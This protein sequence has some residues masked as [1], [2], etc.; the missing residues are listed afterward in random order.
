MGYSVTDQSTVQTIGKY[1]ILGTLGR[2]SMGVVYK[3]LDPE[4]ERVVA[5]KTLRKINPAGADTDTALE[6]F[7]LEARSAGKIR[8]PNVITI[9]EV[10]IEGDLPYLVMDYVQGQSLADI[11]KSQ[12]RI[13]PGFVIHLLKQAAAGIDAAHRCG[14]IHRDIKPRNMIVDSNKQLYVLDFG[15]A[16]LDMTLGEIKSDK[17]RSTVMGTPGY[18]SPEQVLDEGV[19]YRTDIFSLAVVAFECFTGKRP[20]PGEN[21]TEIVAN[22][23]NAKPLALTSLAPDLPLA[24]EADFERALSKNKDERFETAAEMIGCFEDSLR[25]AGKQILSKTGSPSARERKK[26]VWK[27]L[28]VVS[29][30]SVRQ[31]SSREEA[32]GSDGPGR[33]DYP[34]RSLISANPGVKK[35]ESSYYGGP[36]KGAT[37]GSIFQNSNYDLTDSSNIGYQSLSGM[38]VL[39]LLFGVLCIFLGTYLLWIIT[40]ENSQL[41]GPGGEKVKVVAAAP[42]NAAVL[43]FPSEIDLKISPVDYDLPPASK[44]VHEMS[45][46]ELLGVLVSNS[47]P[48][49]ELVSALKEARRRKIPKLVN[50]VVHVLDNQSY[51]VRIEAVKILGELK[52]RRAVPK[53]VELLDDID[54]L[55]RIKTAQS[56]G[57]LGS[58]KAIGYLTV[59]L[60]KEQLPGVKKAIKNAIEK[61]NGFP[62]SK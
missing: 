25:R 57:M 5:I 11:I 45:S 7:R 49:G 1:R 60:S 26:S 15:I 8:H 27:S 32:N 46:R 41:T 62:L 35:S 39:I 14:V 9:F 54:P 44:A 24:L 21:F 47:L 58:R 56:L 23:L 38:Q 19:D 34:V 12:G 50:A 13:A 20:F 55:V 48:A 4:I 40:E 53:L 29:E 43:T 31:I 6:R 16:S 2:G 61:I 51:L 30:P 28:S 22:I 17:S 33:S 42:G 37:P 52:D 3:A 10:N 36:K 18:M 59:R